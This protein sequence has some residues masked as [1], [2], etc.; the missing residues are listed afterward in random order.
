[1]CDVHEEGRCDAMHEVK[2][3]VERASM[4]KGESLQS[5]CVFDWDVI[6]FLKKFPGRGGL[7]GAA[8]LGGGAPGGGARHHREEGR[9]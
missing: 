6:G 4:S 1:M 7:G 9:A 5:T 3:S 8:G 2:H